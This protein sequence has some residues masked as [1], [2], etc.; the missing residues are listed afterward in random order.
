MFVYEIAKLFVV[1]F[2][3]GCVTASIV[4]GIAFYKTSKGAGASFTRL[5]RRAG[6]LEMVTVILIA[7]GTTN[8][9]VLDKLSAEATVGI[10]SGIVGYV[11]GGLARGKSSSRD[12]EEE[13]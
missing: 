8:L 11:L 13:E 6:I 1:V 7:A 9:R 4:G 12:Q 2:A 3:I 10:L 5:I